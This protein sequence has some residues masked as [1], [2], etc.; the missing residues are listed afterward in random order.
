M[1]GF[2][3][4]VAR[5]I[6]ALKKKGNG[7]LA[8]ELRAVVFKYPHRKQQ[9]DVPTKEE[10]STR[11]RELMSEACIEYLRT[12]DAKTEDIRSRFKVDQV[13]KTSGVLQKLAEMAV[14]MLEDADT[15]EREEH[16][17]EMAD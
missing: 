16:Q 10:F 2:Q 13:L 5:A 7:A 8:A 15:E 11:F 1:T 3:K 6:R 14:D 4:V 9:E 17:E 12:L